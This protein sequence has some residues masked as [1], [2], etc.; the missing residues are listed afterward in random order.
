M[1]QKID[2]TEIMTEQGYTVLNPNPL[3]LFS[4]LRKT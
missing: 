1:H 3:L 4:G 2:C